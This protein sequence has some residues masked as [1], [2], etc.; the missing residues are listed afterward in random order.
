M[1]WFRKTYCIQV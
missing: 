1:L